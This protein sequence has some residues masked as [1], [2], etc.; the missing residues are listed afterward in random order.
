MQLRTA[1]TTKLRR[2]EVRVAE[3]SMIQNRGLRI[4]S[5]LAKAD[6]SLQ[7]KV[8]FFHQSKPKI[9]N[10]DSAMI[11]VRSKEQVDAATQIGALLGS[12]LTISFSNDPRRLSLIDVAC[13]EPKRFVKDSD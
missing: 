11:R 8:T 9:H 4:L 10:Q 1:F 6:M 2:P 7:C 13:G 5:F 12:N 3:S